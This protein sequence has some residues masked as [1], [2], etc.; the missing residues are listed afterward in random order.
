MWTR[1]I[2]ITFWQFWKI[3]STGFCKKV[4]V[5]KQALDKLVTMF[6][7]NDVTHFGIKVIK[8]NL[9]H[10]FTAVRCTFKVKTLNLVCYQCND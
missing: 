8:A 1:V 4:E 7:L 10:E 6:F 9:P 2:D 5:F 3:G